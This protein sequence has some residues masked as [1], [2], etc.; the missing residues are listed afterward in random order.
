MKSAGYARHALATVVALALS[1]WPCVR[2]SAQPA[3]DEAE[4]RAHFKLGEA[5]YET[6]KFADATHEFE[7]AYRISQRPALLYN[8]YLANRDAGRLQAAALALRSYL[9]AVPGDPRAEQLRARLAALEASVREPASGKP[10]GGPDGVKLAA[11]SGAAAVQPRPPVAPDDVAEPRVA[12]TKAAPV[13]AA[14]AR[15][16]A[17]ESQPILPLIFVG[18][19]GTLL[20]G[21]GVTQVLAAGDLSDYQKLCPNRSCLQGSSPSAIAANDS[22]AKELQSQ[23][24]S[25]VTASYVLLAAGVVTA[26]VGGALYLLGLLG[27]GKSQPEPTPVGGLAFACLPG[28]CMASLRGTL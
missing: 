24:Q 7:E 11:P 22:K 15:P 9:Q 20:I 23:G 17:A 21:A 28:Q 12:E 13:D 16:A 10:D 8:L 5:Y 27:K 3:S 2:A 25:F 4:A 6:G 1:A 14:G 26:G 18:L 19:G